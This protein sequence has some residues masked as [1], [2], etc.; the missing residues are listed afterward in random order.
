MLTNPLSIVQRIEQH[1]SPR[2]NRD[3]PVPSSTS[4][5]TSGDM[6]FT[7]ASQTNFVLP[8]QE[9]SDRLLSRYFDFATPSYRFFHRPTVE[10]WAAELLESSDREEYHHSKSLTPAKKAA[11]FLVWAQ[12]LEYHE[13]KST[14]EISR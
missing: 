11:V 13:L 7:T 3:R 2:R 9:H 5:F 14:S 1:D 8:K 6:S 12:A 4:I 10:K